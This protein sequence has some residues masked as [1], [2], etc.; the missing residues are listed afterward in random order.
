MSQDSL[1]PLVKLL[2]KLPGLG[3]RS[4][5]RALIHLLENKDAV[6]TPLS[7]ELQNALERIQTCDVCGNLD[8]ASPCHVCTNPNRDRHILCVVESVSDLWALEKSSVFKGQFHV[9]GGTL[10]AI[11]G[12]TP[13]DLRNNELIKRVEKGDISEVILALSATVDGQTTSHF[14]ASELKHFDINISAISHGIP[15]GGELD[16]LDEGTL[17]TAL[18]ARRHVT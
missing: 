17:S 14:I 4:S 6:M 1:T 9:L 5:R 12:V 8:I 18:Q 11:D 2:A 13:D 16:Y 7:R 3:P 10:S 15:V